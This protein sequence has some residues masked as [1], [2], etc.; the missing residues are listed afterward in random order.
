MT[1]PDPR[2]NEMQRS[3]GC[4]RGCLVT[5]LVLV[6]LLVV[7]SL[8]AYVGG[9]AYIDRNLPEWRVR[10]PAIRLVTSVLQL[11]QG[12]T[13]AQA[14]VP[15]A[16]GRQAGVD[17]RSLLPEDIP[18][19]AQPLQETYSISQAHVTGYQLLAEPYDAVLDQVRGSMA[20]HGWE[21]AGEEQAQEGQ[22]MVWVKG[23]RD[24]QVEV[25]VYE[26]NSELWLR[27]SGVE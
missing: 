14:P 10:Y 22:L 27:C 19:F 26:G 1:Q 13:P 8:A 4:L 7:G 15:S 6:V 5:T 18:V 9:R 11:R 17:D 12:L 20:G 23:A 21:M 24:C 16:P 3:G 2:Q 25:A